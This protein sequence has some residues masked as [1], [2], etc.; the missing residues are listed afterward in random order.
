MQSGGTGERC[1][2]TYSRPFVHGPA[3]KNIRGILMVHYMEHRVMNF[4]IACLVTGLALL[5]MTI[6]V[7]ASAETISAQGPGWKFNATETPIINPATGEPYPS[8]GAFEQALFPGLW[9][10]M[11]PAARD[12]A[13]MT[14][15][16]NNQ[17]DLS[18]SLNELQQAISL[19]LNGARITEAEYLAKVL[20]DLWA[21]LPGWQKEQYANEE[22]KWQG[23]KLSPDIGQFTGP[24]FTKPRPSS[25]GTGTFNTTFPVNSVKDW[26]E[27]SI[28]PQ[29]PSGWAHTL[30]SGNWNAAPA[31]PVPGWSSSPFSPFTTGALQ[32]AKLP[33]LAA[34]H[35]SLPGAG[36]GTFTDLLTGTFGNGASGGVKNSAGSSNLE[37]S[38]FVSAS[39]LINNFGY[40]AGYSSG[41]Y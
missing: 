15:A 23:V 38:E 28:M 25:S 9:D 27:N 2:H 30:P 32:P 11:S 39:G 29:V 34:P 14:P 20:P 4:M 19:Q 36:T 3:S 12:K 35:L 22:H 13:N 37:Y 16:V 21:A 7:P 18:Y 31:T 5:S 24:Y 8:L 1:D 6:V 33:T 10:Q 17:F 41:L 26:F 40:S